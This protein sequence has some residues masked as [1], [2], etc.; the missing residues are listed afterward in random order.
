MALVLAPMTPTPHDALVRSIF[1]R[2]RHAADEFAAVLPPGL[3]AELDLS[4]LAPVRESF[5][6]DELR[7][8][9]ADLLF[10]VEL[11]NGGRSYVHLLLEHQS[12]HDR[13]LAFRILKYQA[14]IWERHLAEH[15]RAGGLPPI[16]A[17]LLANGP[18]RWRAPT[19]FSALFTLDPDLR[20]RFA[21]HL[22]DFEIVIDDLARLTE[23]EILSRKMDA[24]ARLALVALAASRTRKRITEHV[25]HHV[26]ALSNE[27]QDPSVVAPLASLARYTFEV[28]EASPKRARAEFAAALAP[29][30]RSR[31]MT[32][33][34]MMRA[35][36][37]LEARREC[38]LDLLQ[39]RFGLVDAATR[40][41]IA[42]ASMR[43]LVAWLRRGFVAD[44]IES[45]FAGT[46]RHRRG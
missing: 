7:G 23:P 11:R 5:L 33:A 9:S 40:R 22:L 46:P 41:R 31:V 39:V 3:R 42:E 8:S 34:D 4:T 30:I 43:Q 35:E 26:G 17:I 24:V 25:A 15:P 16:V 27:L 1:G 20:A 12:R 32:T 6:D 36:G 10:T 38:L 2:P 19:S 28:G 44:S 13:W 21:P 37:R 14:R 45:T 18:R 29:T